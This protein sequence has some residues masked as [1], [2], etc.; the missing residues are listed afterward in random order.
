MQI[1]LDFPMILTIIIPFKGKIEFLLS[2]LNSFKKYLPLLSIDYEV[3]IITA[4]YLKVDKELNNFKNINIKVV[5]EESYSGI[6]NAMNIGIKSSKGDFLIFINC[7]DYIT[8]SFVYF[9]KNIKNNLITDD[10]L[11][12]ITVAQKINSKTIIRR[13]PCRFKY[14][15]LVWNM[16]S[17]WHT[18]PRE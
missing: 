11:L 5:K 16:V 9:F 12:A 10:T 7:G 2:T 1:F 17:L 15:G 3:F 18:V 4:E 8:K 14:A 6:Y 13:I